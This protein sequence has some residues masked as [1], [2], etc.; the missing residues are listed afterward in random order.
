VGLRYQCMV[1]QQRDPS[2]GSAAAYERERHPPELQCL[3]TRHTY[4]T[5]GFVPA[6]GLVLAW[7]DGLILHGG[8]G[9]VSGFVLVGWCRPVRPPPP[10]PLEA[11]Y[12]LGRLHTAFEC[13]IATRAWVLWAWW[14]GEPGTGR[15]GVGLNRAGVVGAARCLVLRTCRQKTDLHLPEELNTCHLP[16]PFHTCWCYDI[17]YSVHGWR[18]WCW[19]TKLRTRST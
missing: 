4:S 3:G 11:S 10:L 1:Q 2:A 7:F 6:V 19:A 17:G 5:G 8:L 9:A 18:R 14:Q 15:A 12:L 16:P 13:G